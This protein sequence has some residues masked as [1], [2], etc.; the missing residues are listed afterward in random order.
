ME[1]DSV[2]QHVMLHQAAST[3]TALVYLFY[4]VDDVITPLVR[5]LYVEARNSI[6]NSRSEP[7]T[8]GSNARA[9]QN[10]HTV[11]CMFS[12]LSVSQI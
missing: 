7:A 6:S 3:L 2:S 5:S 9:L 1:S 12:V 11:L 10:V 8:S 4:P